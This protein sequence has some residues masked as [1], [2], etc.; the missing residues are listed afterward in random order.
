MRLKLL[1]AGLFVVL[2]STGCHTILLK[3]YGFKDP[4]FES[5][6]SIRE[7]QK[8][9]GFEGFPYYGL[10]WEYWKQNKVFSVPDV[11]VFDNSGRYIPYKDSLKPNCNGPAELFLTELNTE[12][13]YNY[14]DKYSLKSFIDYFEGQECQPLI[15]EHNSKIDFYIFMTYTV[16]S[17][18]K[19]FKEKSKIWLDSLQNNKNIHYKLIMLNEDWKECWSAEQKQFFESGD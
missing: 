8:Q 17:G 6:A 4:D 11:F 9:I 18:K 10:K 7:F 14:S 16:F 5:D 1:F 2:M 19:I 12:K 13:Q 15:F 3:W